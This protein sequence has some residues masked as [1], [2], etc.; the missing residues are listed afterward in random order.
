MRKNLPVTNTE[1]TF[2]PSQKLIS[3][4]DL[5]GKIRTAIKPLL[6]SAASI[7]RS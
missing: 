3:S 7:V 4:T 1:R 2:S 6:K 5:K